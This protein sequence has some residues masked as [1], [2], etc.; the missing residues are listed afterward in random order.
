MQPLRTCRE[1]YNVVHWTPLIKNQDV[2]T[3]YLESHPP[4]LMVFK[5]ATKKKDKMFMWCN[6]SLLPSVILIFMSRPSI[7]NTHNSISNKSAK[8][9]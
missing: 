5:M 9:K 4:F 2:N 7:F 1:W 6:I 3:R 8:Y